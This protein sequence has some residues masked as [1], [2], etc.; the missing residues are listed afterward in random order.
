MRANE[1]LPD[2]CIGDIDVVY[3]GVKQNF[4]SSLDQSRTRENHFILL[5][6]FNQN[7]R[8]ITTC[9]RLLRNPA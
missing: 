3:A 6:S 2:G 4:S 5:P 7:N 8:R 9:A 1:C